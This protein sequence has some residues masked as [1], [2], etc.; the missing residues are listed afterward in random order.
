MTNLKLP[1]YLDYASTT[2]ADKRVAQKI[3]EHLTLEGNFGNPASRSHAYGW[4]AEESV[5]EARA[6]VANLVNCDPREI[7]LNE[8]DSPYSVFY[9]AEQKRGKF[10]H[11][12]YVANH[13]FVTEDSSTMISE[14]VSSGKSVI[15]VYP[16]SIKTPKKYSDIIDKY[17]RLNFV[18]RR[19]LRIIQATDSIQDRDISIAVSKALKDFQTSLMD[20]LQLD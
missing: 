6:H 4:S 5:E 18:E 19:S 14:A 7:V 20:R 17:Q 12:L 16:Q 3:F 2:P 1:I 10:H 8:Q 9:H 11:L 13:I 15:S